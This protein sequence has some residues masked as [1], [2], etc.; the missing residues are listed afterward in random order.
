MNA[1]LLARNSLLNLA[2]QV[3]PLVFAVVA[4]PPLVRGL[5]A[6]RFGILTLAW[7][8]IGYFSLFEFGLARALT[9]TVA[10]RLGKGDD[11]DLPAVAWTAL[12]MMLGLGLVGA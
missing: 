4:I 6:E 3:T 9:Q 12:L 1:R 10:Q 7:A 5:G 11:E 2:A 8:A